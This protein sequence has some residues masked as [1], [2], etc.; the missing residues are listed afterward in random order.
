[1]YKYLIISSF[2]SFIL[3][4]SCYKESTRVE[5]TDKESIYLKSITEPVRNLPLNTTSQHL[6]R[7][8]T[9]GFNGAAPEYSVHCYSSLNCTYF[10]KEYTSSENSF[11]KY[12][13]IEQE[14]PVYEFLLNRTDTT[15]VFLQGSNFFSD[16]VLLITTFVSP[17]PDDTL[18]LFNKCEMTLKMQEYISGFSSSHNWIL[19]ASKE[20]AYADNKFVSLWSDGYETGKLIVQLNGSQNKVS[21]VD[22]L[23]IFQNMFRTETTKFSTNSCF[24]LNIEKESILLG[25]YGPDLFSEIGFYYSEISSDTNFRRSYASDVESY[26]EIELKKK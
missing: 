25:Y 10:Y 16:T 24:V 4:T 12:L 26:L 17:I 15:L 7:L 14:T 9:V 13:C 6:I 5:N 3:L 19:S 18:R 21:L 1:M 22:Y 2:T 8:T 23:N 11:E 20:V